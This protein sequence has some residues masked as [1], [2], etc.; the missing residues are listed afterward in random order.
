MEEVVGERFFL[1]L[2]TLREL[3]NFTCV[4]ILKDVGVKTDFTE[5]VFTRF[6]EE[7]CGGMGGQGL[8]TNE[9][10]EVVWEGLRGLGEY[11]VEGTRRTLEIMRLNTV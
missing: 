3:L 10:K 8:I 4:Q 6:E 9:T 11:R 1:T 5:E 2:G 7:G